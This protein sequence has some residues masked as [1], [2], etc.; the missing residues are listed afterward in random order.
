MN[1][2]DFF[3]HFHPLIVHLPVGILSLFIILG[4][5]FPPENTSQ[6]MRLFRFMLLI[7]AIAA[8]LSIATGFLL[9]SSGEYVQK[10]L[11]TH[12]VSG[13]ILTL[14][15]WLL[16]LKLIYLFSMRKSLMRSALFS[17]AVLLIFT[18]HAGGSLTHGSEFLNP[19]PLADWFSGNS[20]KP[21]VITMDSPAEDVV[22]NIFQEKCVSCHGP[23]KQKGDL[24]LDSP[25][26]MLTSADLALLHADNSLLIE[27]ITLPVDDDDHMPPQGK[28][29]L[30]KDEIAFLSWWITNG[31]AFDKSLAELK[32]PSNLQGMLTEIMAENSLLPEEPVTPAPEAA[33][34]Q[35]RKLGVVILPVADHSNYLTASLVNTLPENTSKI[36]TELLKTNAKLIWLNMDFQNPENA[37]WESLGQMT[38]LRKLSL[39]ETN[40][41]DEQMTLLKSLQ[42]LVYLNLSGTQ[43][44]DLTPLENLP[45]LRTL[46][47]YNSM[48]TPLGLEQLQAK[49]P[50]LTIDTGNYQVPALASDTTEFT[51]ADLK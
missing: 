11:T 13:I 26:A 17:L 36:M 24:R 15:N 35:L 44:S 3:G 25:D 45:N 40:F 50:D 41:T 22:S 42:N 1:I 43:V 18:G 28:K 16:Y 4:L 32:L 34:E 10:L 9:S 51:K 49:F 29:Q 31:A 19:P 2:F 5:F 14:I 6:S 7:S 48:T 30:S 33:I 37:G 39:R 21:K 47:L 23:N 20:T 38:A 27:R 12:Q 8:S 46:Y